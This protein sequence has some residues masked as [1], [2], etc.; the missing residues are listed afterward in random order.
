MLRTLRRNG[1]VERSVSVQ[2]F[3]FIFVLKRTRS[4]V[5]HRH[6]NTSGRYGPA[7]LR[8]TTATF[9]HSRLLS[10][11]TPQIKS[12]PSTSKTPAPIPPETNVSTPRK[13][14]V[15][16]KPAPVK[17]SISKATLLEPV[18]ISQAARNSQ[19]HDSKLRPPAESAAH[20]TSTSKSS[21]TPLSPFSVITAS[22]IEAQRDIKGAIEHGVFVPPPAGAGW[23][24]KLLHQAKELAVRIIL[25]CVY[26]FLANESLMGRNRNSTGTVS[27]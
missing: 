23:A 12:D 17:P 4:I 10:T 26:L 15:D 6:N 5:A 21:T 2:K 16:L 25:L 24:R 18:V 27:K 13:S 7:A 1:F 20:H 19:V 9:T 14:K 8:L 3:W 11:S 22:V